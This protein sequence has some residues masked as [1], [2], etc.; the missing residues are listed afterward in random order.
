MVFSCQQIDCYNLVSKFCQEYIVYP[1]VSDH[2]GKARFYIFHWVNYFSGKQ[3]DTKESE[4]FID[5]FNS[6]TE[7]QINGPK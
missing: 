6:Y 7:L 5:F 4:T 1:F 3:L 2:T